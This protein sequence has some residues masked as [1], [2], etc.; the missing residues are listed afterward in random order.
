[1]IYKC[2]G[3]NVLLEDM[4]LLLL[5]KN[6]RFRLVIHLERAFKTLVG[7]FLP[8]TEERSSTSNW[9]AGMLEDL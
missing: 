7:A 9:W 8:V 4:K 3:T 5:R 6:F 2:T 1:M